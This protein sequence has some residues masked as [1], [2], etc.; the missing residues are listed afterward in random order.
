MIIKKKLIIEKVNLKDRLR[1][2]GNYILWGY[3]E[4]EKGCNYERLHRGTKKECE[5]KRRCLE[6]N[7][8]KN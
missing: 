8:I 5:E 6:C 3:C 4:S 2:K 7:L 1:E